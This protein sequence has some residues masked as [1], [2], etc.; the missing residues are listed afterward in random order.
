MRVLKALDVSRPEFVPREVEFAG[1]HLSPDV[2]FG[3]IIAVAV[4][5]LRVFLVGGGVC[6]D[7]LVVRL[8][9]VDDESLVREQLGGFQRNVDHRFGPAGSGVVV[10]ALIEPDVDRLDKGR[11]NL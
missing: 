2:I 4:D 8:H 11:V 1:E 6:G 3:E 5:L 7:R 10:P 9:V